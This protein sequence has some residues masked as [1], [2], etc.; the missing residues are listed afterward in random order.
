[1]WTARSY[2]VSDFMAPSATMRVR[3]VARDLG[4]GSLVEAGV[5]D[6]KVTN[7]D[8][9]ATNPADLNG[10]GLVNATDLATL[11]GLWGAT[12][13]VADVNGDGIV[14]AIDLA[15]LMGAWNG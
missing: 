10:D 11:L 13:G 14:D 1:M 6:F 9:G 4:I 8:C 15:L 12:S 2:L 5:D 3:F 7:I